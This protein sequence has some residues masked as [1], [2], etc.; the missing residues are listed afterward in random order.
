MTANQTRAMGGPNFEGLMTSLR[1]GLVFVAK[2]G[3]AGLLII[4]AGILAVAT[5][6]V[7]LVI[8]GIALLLRFIGRR[9]GPVIL[10]PRGG[11]SAD[12]NGVTLE[13]RRTHHG[14]TVE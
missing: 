3:V 1:N 4:A 9:Q 7:G 11:E 6:I 13:A 12:K 14:W 2:L 8:A 10:T 5:A